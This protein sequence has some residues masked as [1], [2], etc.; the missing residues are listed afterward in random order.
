MASIQSGT[1]SSAKFN[2]DQQHAINGLIGSV[3]ALDKELAQSHHVISELCKFVQV[4]ELLN[5]EIDALDLTLKNTVPFVA[6]ANI[7]MNDA[8]AHEQVLENI[9][10]L[11]SSPDFLLY[12]TFET[13]KKLRMDEAG[14][15]AIAD[16]YLDFLQTKG[17]Y[18][19]NQPQRQN[20]FNQVPYPP[21]PGQN[22]PQV[23]AKVAAVDL[24]RS[25]NP[26]AAR[27]LQRA[28]MQ[29]AY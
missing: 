22:T 17:K 2:A 19:P 28:R 6:A 5:K 25:G 12:W 4:N 21:A 7:W 9:C 11:M 8:L 10:G 1:T 27:I 20:S 13:F 16:A 29:G 14:F 18:S 23:D 24:M 3:Q 15:D 26:D